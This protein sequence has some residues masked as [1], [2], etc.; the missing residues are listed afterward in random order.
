MGFTFPNASAL[1]LAPFG[2]NA[3]CASALLGGIQMS[4]G[5]STSALVSVFQNNTALPM[6][7]IMACCATGAWTV[8]LVGRKIICQ[9]AGQNAV[10]Q[11]DVEMISTL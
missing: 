11:E 10:K 3:G 1:L 8:L 2:H 5:A 9:K 7:G 6:T 4:I